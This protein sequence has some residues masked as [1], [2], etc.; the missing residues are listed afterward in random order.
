MILSYNMRVKTIDRELFN[1]FSMN[2]RLSIG[3][4]P[5]MIVPNQ[6]Y[7]VQGT[8]ANTYTL[9]ANHKM[10]GITS[11]EIR[12]VRLQAAI[13]VHNQ[14]EWRLYTRIRTDFAPN[15]DLYAGLFYDAAI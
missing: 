10:I 11:N 4:L 9:I 7:R 14:L 15:H 6:K 1:D 12:G 5:D 8:K 3:D 2:N 13:N